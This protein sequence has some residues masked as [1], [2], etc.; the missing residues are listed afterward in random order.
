LITMA[1]LAVFRQ[2]RIPYA[3]AL[4]ASVLYAFLPS[5][6]LKGEHHIFMDVFFQVPLAILVV[7][8]VCEERPPL[9]R[10]R[11]G[12]RWPGLELRRGRSVAAVLICAMTSCLGLYYAFFTGFLLV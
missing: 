10:D 3:A 12:A 5:R 8:W 4:A 11:G 7:L 1:A 2:Y 6:L 9:V